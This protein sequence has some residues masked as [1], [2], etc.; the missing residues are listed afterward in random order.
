MKVLRTIK[1]ATQFSAFLHKIGFL[2]CLVGPKLVVIAIKIH[3]VENRYS[4]SLISATTLIFNADNLHSWKSMFASY[5]CCRQ[6]ARSTLHIL[7]AVTGM[8]VGMNVF[9]ILSFE[10]QTGVL[11]VNCVDCLDRTNIAQFV[12]GK[13]VLGLQV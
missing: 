2:L 4:D 13:H 9:I 11:R 3:L 5:F 10:T 6:L 1:Y 8:N 12:V 7:D